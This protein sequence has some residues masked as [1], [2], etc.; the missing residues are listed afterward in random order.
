MLI[1]NTR[2]RESVK[3]PYEHE[4]VTKQYKGDGYKTISISSISSSSSMS[5]RLHYGVA[6]AISCKD[7]NLSDGFKSD[8]LKIDNCSWNISKPVWHIDPLSGNESS[9]LHIFLFK[10]FALSCFHSLRY[11]WQIVVKWGRSFEGALL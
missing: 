8:S 7:T 3:K 4:K 10:W 2:K 5:V 11:R 9:S 1:Y 6:S